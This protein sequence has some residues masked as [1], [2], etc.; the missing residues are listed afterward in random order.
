MAALESALAGL[1]GRKRE[2]L[3]LLDEA[4][5]LTKQLAEA[6]DRKDQVSVQMVLAM[7]DGPVRAMRDLEDGI[8]AFLPTLPDEDARRCDELLHGAAAETPEEEPLAA[9]VARFQSRLKSVVELD[10]KLSVRIG[11]KKSFY[12]I[13]Q[14]P[15]K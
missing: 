2:Q 10:E 8:E 4:S 9:L 15:Q 1:A 5:D 13:Y 6:I 14:K 7:R 3:I 12:H 11:G